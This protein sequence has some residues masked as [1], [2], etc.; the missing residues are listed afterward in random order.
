MQNSRY[1]KK[2]EP[3]SLMERCVLCG[4]LTDT[5]RAEDIRG[6][7]FYIDGVGQLCRGCYLE[8]FYET[9]RSAYDRTELPSAN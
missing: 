8:L 7:E 1:K 3:E 4:E 2:P 5:P 9:R 6:R